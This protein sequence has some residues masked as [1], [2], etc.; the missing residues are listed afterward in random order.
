MNRR[1]VLATVAISACV[2][3]QCGPTTTD[4]VLSISAKP[5]I[6][7]KPTTSVTLTVTAIDELNKSGTGTVTVTSAAGSLTA[8]AEI[9]LGADGTGTTPFTCDVGADPAC[10]GRVKISATWSHGGKSYDASVNVNVTPVPDSGAGGGSAG[11][12]GMTGDG[13]TID[14]GVFVIDLVFQKPSLVAATGDS[15]T[16]T[17]TVKT[18]DGGATVVGQP[19]LFTTTRGSF[20]AAPGITSSTVPTDMTGKATVTLFSAG[21]S[22]G[23]ATVTAGALDSQSTGT[24][25]F[26]DV[27]SIIYIADARTKP[28]IGIIQSNRDTTTPIFFQVLNAQNMGVG[29]VEVSFSA[30]GPSGI[31]TSPRGITDDTGYVF[32]TLQSGDDVGIATV[33]ATVTATQG[34]GAEKSTKHPGTPVVGGRPSDKGFSFACEKK[35]IGALHVAGSVPPTRQQSP[36]TCTVNLTDRFGKPVGPTSVQFYVEVGSATNTP[37]VTPI[38]GALGEAKLAYSPVST[39][40]P[41]DVAPLAGEPSYG[42]GRNPRDMLVTIIAV[43]NGEEDFSDGSGDAGVVNGKWDPGEWFVDLPEPFVDVNDNNVWD[44]GEPPP[45]SNNRDCAHPDGGL[46]AGWD[47]PNGCWDA[48]T[49]IWRATHVVFS[50]PLTNPIDFSPIPYPLTVAPM[51]MR[52]F[53]FTWADAWGNKSSADGA[54]IAATLQNLTGGSVTVN[55]NLTG[56]QTG[57]MDVQYQLVQATESAIGSGVFTIDGPCMTVN[58]PSPTSLRTRCLRRTAFGPFNKGNEGSVT[59]TGRTPQALPDGGAPG[60]LNGSLLMTAQH[61]FSTPAQQAIPVVLQ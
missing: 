20:N 52:T 3:W 18:T 23:S 53:P 51:E 6:I 29:G 41:V 38:S 58:T 13:G 11:D 54:S 7:D 5:L 59:I 26:A 8:G 10:S 43:V 61:T 35:N 31:T 21:A 36:I 48:D 56:D 1:I 45:I 19:I 60:P 30:A 4:P 55:A 9:T 15:T 44:P 28:T 27:A 16:V 49:Q 46:S 42:N 47:G 2:L 32:T 34:T 25:L 33:T 22:T 14:A 57:A 39:S 40:L 24:V 12:G 50:G 17:A 37:V